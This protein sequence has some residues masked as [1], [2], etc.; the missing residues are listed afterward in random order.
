MRESGPV[1]RSSPNKIGTSPAD[2]CVRGYM[3]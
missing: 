3:I 1:P 2:E